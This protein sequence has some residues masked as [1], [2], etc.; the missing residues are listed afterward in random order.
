MLPIAIATMSGSAVSPFRRENGSWKLARA[1][2][3]IAP[4]S[5]QCLLS[6]SRLVP[7]G[8]RQ[9]RPLP[10]HRNR[11]LP[12]HL[13]VGLPRRAAYSVQAM[14]GLQG[15]PH[16]VTR[17]A[18]VASGNRANHALP[19]RAPVGVVHRGMWRRAPPTTWSSLRSAVC[20]L[21]TCRGDENGSDCQ[22]ATSHH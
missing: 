4:V 13:S 6:R 14:S 11:R 9:R 22:S 17:C 7:L 16:R 18:L 5:A 19:S 1:L 2:S 21:T 8:A 20:K 12:S 15:M 3:L 10:G